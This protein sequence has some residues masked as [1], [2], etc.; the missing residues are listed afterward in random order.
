MCVKVRQ[1]IT[2]IKVAKRNRNKPINYR[3]E[4][5]GNVKPKPS[6]LPQG[7]RRT[8]YSTLVQ[9]AP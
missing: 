3:N 9:S 1:C 7:Q 8:R 6:D 2:R 5:N 4:K